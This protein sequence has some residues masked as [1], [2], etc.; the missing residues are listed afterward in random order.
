MFEP[1][2]SSLDVLW[3]WG[4]VVSRARPFRLQKGLARETRGREVEVFK[5]CRG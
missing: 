3:S 4:R 2:N 5:Q 1:A